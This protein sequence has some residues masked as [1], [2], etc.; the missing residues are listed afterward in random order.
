MAATCVVAGVAYWHQAKPQLT[1]RSR[2][3]AYA[4][5]AAYVAGIAV[6]GVTLWR[7]VQRTT[8]NSLALSRSFYGTLRVVATRAEGGQDVE[9]VLQHGRIDHGSQYQSP[10]RRHLPFGYYSPK[11]GFGL[12][13]RLHPNKEARRVGVIGLGTGMIAAYGAAGDTIRFY[14]IN[15]DVVRIARSMFTYLADSKGQCEVVLGDGRIS[16]EREPNQNFDVLAVDAFNSDA[17]PVHLLTWEAF[18]TYLRHTGPDGVIAVNIT[19]RY[20]DLWPVMNGAAHHFGLA[21]AFVISAD[22]R[23]GGAVC[24]VLLTRNKPFLRAGDIAAATV[25]TDEMPTRICSW[26][27]DYSNLFQVMTRLRR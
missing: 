17:I 8:E 18:E 24:W 6:L 25:T 20:L 5:A 27:D 21:A 7:D 22:E 1:W 12:T 3:A 2:S 26:T 23:T 15:P 19:N 4:V 11:S 14:E 9:L 16:L 13:I 10:E